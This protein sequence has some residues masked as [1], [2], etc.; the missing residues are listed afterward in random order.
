MNCAI[1]ACARARPTRLEEA[2]SIFENSDIQAN[3][4]TFGAL[5][6]AC[7]RARNANRALS[8]LRSMKSK[9][10][11]APNA[12]IYS[13]VISAV[14]RTDPPQPQLALDLIYEATIEK[15]LYMNVVGFNAAIA[16]C[17]RAGDWQRAMKVLNQMEGVDVLGDS[18]IGNVT[19][20]V[21]PDSVTYGTM[22]S[23]CEKSEQWEL[24][25][26]YAKIAMEEK[27]LQLDALAITS[28]LHAC[29]QLSLADEALYY[30]ELMKKNGKKRR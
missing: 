3:D 17:A 26:Q 1:D 20:F 29:Q 14:A 4:F 30:L 7:A 5:V 13:T 10:G 6:S 28:V 11:I 24:V 9:Y 12:V 18:S 19:T 15:R 8:V 2:F 16:A 22:L 21:P 23:A 25:L 27:N